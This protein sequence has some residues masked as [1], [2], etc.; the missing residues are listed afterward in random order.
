MTPLLG[1]DLPSLVELPESRPALDLLP[2]PFPASAFAVRGSLK[3]S[4]METHGPALTELVVQQSS[5]VHGI[6]WISTIVKV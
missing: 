3:R 1:S 5:N 6:E 4:Q 2:L